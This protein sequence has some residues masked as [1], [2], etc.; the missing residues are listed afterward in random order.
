MKDDVDPANH[1]HHPKRNRMQFQLLTDDDTDD[2]DAN[3]KWEEEDEAA[4]IDD[5]LVMKL[6]EQ[7]VVH[8]DNGHI[9]HQKWWWEFDTDQ[10][11]A[12]VVDIGRGNDVLHCQPSV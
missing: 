12:V 6:P 1:H 11:A 3:S 5:Y 10:L 8:L 7:H 4:K 2:D 9:F